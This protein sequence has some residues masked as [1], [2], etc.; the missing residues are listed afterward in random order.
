MATRSENGAAWSRTICLRLSD[1]FL[2]WGNQRDLFVRPILMMSPRLEALLLSYKLTLIATRQHAPGQLSD[3]KAELV[4]LVHIGVQRWNEEVMAGIGAVASEISG[5]QLDTTPDAEQVRLAAKV[6]LARL[7][8]AEG[9]TE[10]VLA[11]LHRGDDR[12]FT[13]IYRNLRGVT[14][15]K[16]PPHEEHALLGSIIQELYESAA[17]EARMNARDKASEKPGRRDMS[18]AWFFLAL[19]VAAVAGG[20]VGGEISGRAFSAVGAVVGFVGLAVVLLG[21]GAIFDARSR[22]RSSDLTPEMRGVF[23]RM[24][25]G[26]QNPTAN[27]IESAKRRLRGD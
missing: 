26:K 14:G 24:I 5:K 7:T 17:S 21:L 15:G 3:V 12:P 27:E 16:S 18:L 10:A 22:K 8:E 4:P 6:A 9:D 23:D 13:V 11:A 25:T 2:E 1:R 20:F 19:L